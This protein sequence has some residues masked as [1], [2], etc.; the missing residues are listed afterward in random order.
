MNKKEQAVFKLQL[1]ELRKRLLQE[2]DSAEDAL[3]EDIVKPGEISSVPTHP[4]DVDV[5]GADAEIAIGRTKNCCFC[6]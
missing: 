3:R 1:L 6:R 2:V 5:E 4:A